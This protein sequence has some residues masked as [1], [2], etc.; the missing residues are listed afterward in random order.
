MVAQTLGTMGVMDV[1]DA[2]VIAVVVLT[3]ATGLLYRVR[4]DVLRPQFGKRGRLLAFAG[5][6]IFIAWIVL[7]NMGGPEGW[8]S[9]PAVAVAVVMLEAF[10]LIALIVDSIRAG[11][12]SGRH[13][14]TDAQGQPLPR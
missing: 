3:F 5:L 13:A 4:R 9:H 11:R 2:A 12:I 8:A 10:I 7:L 14:K 1:V 6:A